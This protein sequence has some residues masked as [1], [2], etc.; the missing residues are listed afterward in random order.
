MTFY[1]IKKWFKVTGTITFTQ[2]DCKGPVSITGELQ[3]LSKGKHGWHIH[4][5]GNAQ[6]L[7]PKLIDW[8]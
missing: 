6:D 2:S 8:F 3:G 5:L 7:D 4:T 1:V